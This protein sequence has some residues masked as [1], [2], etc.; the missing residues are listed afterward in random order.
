MKE[1]KPCPFCGKIPVV[2]RFAESLPEID[3]VFFTVTCRKESGCT[4]NPM[5][6]GDTRKE[7]AANWNTR[8]EAA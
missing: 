7:A 8:K 5:A 2:E 6:I 4:T 1:I 3:K